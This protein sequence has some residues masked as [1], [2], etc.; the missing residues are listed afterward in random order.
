MTQH[1]EKGKGRRTSDF[2]AG[3]KG[4]V[5]FSTSFA[6]FLF[7]YKI[8][9]SHGLHKIVLTDENNQTVLFFFQIELGDVQKIK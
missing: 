5:F 1:E 3:L 7:L 6:I 4:M 9:K 2:K 8:S